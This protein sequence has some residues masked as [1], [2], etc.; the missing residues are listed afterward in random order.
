MIQ[1]ECATHTGRGR[2]GGREGTE[3]EGTEREKYYSVL[4]KEILRYATTW[5][6]PED[7]QLN[8]VSPSSQSIIEGQIP[9]DSTLFKV[10][11]IVKLRIRKC[12]GGC[13]ARS[14]WEGKM[15]SY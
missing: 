15:G 11:K 5:T 7:M 2:Q 1:R 12:N 8:E 3:R 9:H 10:S 13:R 14:K 6:N 4:K